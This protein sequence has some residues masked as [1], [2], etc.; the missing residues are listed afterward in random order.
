MTEEKVRWPRE[1][2][3]ELGK[4]RVK[5]QIEQ[6]RKKKATEEYYKR[7]DRSGQED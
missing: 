1:R 4:E 6:V 5:R 2:E 7:K 3:R